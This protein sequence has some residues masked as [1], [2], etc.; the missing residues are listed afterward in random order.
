MTS[1]E[2]TYKY[3]FTKPL[4]RDQLHLIHSAIIRIF[5]RLF[6]VKVGDAARN[7]WLVETSTKNWRDWHVEVTVSWELSPEE[8]DVLDGIV[9]G[10]FYA[11]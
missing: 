11:R 2:Y 10:L 9:E 5:I 7:I 8:K 3:D 6:K 4:T 1:E